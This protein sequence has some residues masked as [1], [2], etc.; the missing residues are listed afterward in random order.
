[1]ASGK[2]RLAGL[3]VGAVVLFLGCKQAS[4]WPANG[5]LDPSQVGRFP[6][7]SVPQNIQ[8]VLSIMDEP[9]DVASAIEPTAVDLE[10]VFQDYTLG[11]SDSVRVTIFELMAE[12][13]EST[14]DRQL[15]ATGYISIP[16]LGS[17][18]IQGMTE[19]DVETYIAD[20]LSQNA[21]LRSPKVSVTA[22]DRRHLTFEMLGGFLASGSYVIPRPNFR[23]L[24]AMAVARDIQPG[25]ETI[26]VLRSYDY[27]K[28]LAA[29]SQPSAAGQVV[30]AAQAPGAAVEASAGTAVASP[31]TQSLP[32]QAELQEAMPPQADQP[33][34]RKPI[35][36]EG[37]WV[38]VPAGAPATAT[39]TRETPAATAS[40]EV[41][42]ATASAASPASGA[43]P[44]VD[45]AAAVT[46]GSGQRV[47]RIAVRDLLRGDPR[48]N[49]VI[50]P[51]DK[52]FAWLGA[53]G[54]FY[55]IGNV[56][57]PG[58]YNLTGRK[59]TVRQA[60]ATAGGL[61]QLAIPE[62]CELIR[63]YKDDQEEIIRLN[64]D[65]I[66]AGMQ[67]DVVLKPNDTIN[68]G[69]NALAPFMATVR[70]AFR[71]TYGFG[72]VY[73]RNYADIDAYAAKENPA[74]I[75]RAQRQSRLGSL[76]K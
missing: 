13:T 51:G 20:Q 50:Q 52:V 16:M 46:E 43:M 72:F 67:P 54:E 59:I 27:G 44:E 10:P 68:V 55:V 31:A 65:A 34:P 3:L 75:H 26:Y 45:W 57:R 64:L 36:I 8:S 40:Q 69:T 61:S 39:A 74:N 35:Y 42:A 41:P 15:S 28:A 76:F 12:G 47:L 1:M 22:V 60:I 37:Q 63:R 58:A 23:L 71:L 5:L 30:P 38:E 21:I 14:F 73:D 32:S 25:I 56:F 62:R 6:T 48:L 18:K 9:L 17:I 70:N 2:V 33:A 7:Q 66:F 24:D 19:R 49:V 11:P 53:V 29:Q 4:H